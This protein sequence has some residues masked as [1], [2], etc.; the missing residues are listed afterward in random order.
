MH[1]RPKCKMQKYKTANIQEIPDDIGYG[2]E[3]LVMPPKV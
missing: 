3:Y 1:H 2:N